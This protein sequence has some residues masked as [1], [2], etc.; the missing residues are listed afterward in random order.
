MGKWR[1]DT[2]AIGKAFGMGMPPGLGLD[3]T[4]TFTSNSI[5]TGGQTT[6]CKFE[7]DGK[8]VI[9]T[10]EGQAASLTFV[11][12]DKDTAALDVGLFKVQY[13]RID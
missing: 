1:M 12:Q 9:V 10:P 2:D 8:R 5:E 7:V 11:L 13:K 6:K 3:A 4:M